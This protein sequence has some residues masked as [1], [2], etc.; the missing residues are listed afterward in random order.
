MSD[1]VFL[2]VETSDL[3]QYKTDMQDAFSGIGRNAKTWSIGDLSNWDV[4]NVTNMSEMFWGCNVKR[5][6]VDNFD[7]RNV[8]EMSSMF[9]G[10]DNLIELNLSSFDTRNVTTMGWMFRDCSNLTYLDISN[11][12]FD[13]V[14][15]AV[16]DYTMFDMPDDAKIYV[17]SEIEQLKIL[18]WSSS[19]RPSTWTTDNVIIK[20]L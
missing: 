2:P 15:F 8:T 16:I 9:Y 19:N 10:C 6:Y 4:S 11:F 5:L 20:N 1:F 17:K 13:N 7:T 14:G 3:E 18:S 12:T